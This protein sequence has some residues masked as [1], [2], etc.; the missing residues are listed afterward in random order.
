M[1][2][3][4]LPHQSK[5]YGKTGSNRLHYLRLDFHG[6]QTTFSSQILYCTGS[7]FYDYLENLKIQICEV[8]V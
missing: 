3:F 7:L 5:N 2:F 8:G 4:S 1:K 6:F